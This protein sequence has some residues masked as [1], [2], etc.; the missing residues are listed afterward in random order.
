MTIE[1]MHTRSVHNK[2]VKLTAAIA[3]EV[4][5]I[6]TTTRLVVALCV[7]ICAGIRIQLVGRTW[8]AKVGS[9][10]NGEAMVVQLQKS[11]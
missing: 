8:I 1:Y 4:Q 6:F 9:I 10:C 7:R 11:R 2:N 3:R 5:A